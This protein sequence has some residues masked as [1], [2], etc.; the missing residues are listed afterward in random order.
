MLEVCSDYPRFALVT[1]RKML[2]ELGA[3]DEVV[4]EVTPG[5][6][7]IDY[8][9]GILAIQGHSRVRAHPHLFGWQRLDWKECPILFH[10]TDAANHQSI[11]NN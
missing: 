8:V 11:V 2:S 1:L 9:I 3:S 7:S 4:G 6:L 5:G 10:Q